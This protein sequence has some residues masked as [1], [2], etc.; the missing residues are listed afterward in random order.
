MIPTDQLK[1]NWW[2]DGFI[3]CNARQLG[4]KTMRWDE[5]IGMFL[6]GGARYQHAAAFGGK[7]ITFEPNVITLDPAS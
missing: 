1:H 6:H 7:T 5:K 4:V 2:Y 3:W